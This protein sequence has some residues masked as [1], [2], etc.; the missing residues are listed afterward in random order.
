MA[1]VNELYQRDPQLQARSETLAKKN[2]F[3]DFAEY[4]EVA[5]NKR[6]SLLQGILLVSSPIRHP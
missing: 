3:K 4:D 5:A 6:F 1:A 2:G